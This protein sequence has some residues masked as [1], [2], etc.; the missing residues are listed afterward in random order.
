MD[1]RQLRYFV[2]IVEHGSFSRAAT[3]LNVAQPALSLHVR[4]MEEA[5]GTPLLHRN[6]RGVTVTEAGAILL[7]H[8]RGILDQLALGEEEIRGRLNDPS[9]TV[10]LGL[11]GTISHI[12]AVP[13]ITAARTRWP[14]I[15]LRIAEAMS[16]FVLEWMR[17]GRIDLAVLYDAVEDHGI[18]TERLLEED[19]L[20]FGPA[21]A[22]AEAGLPSQG[23]PVTFATLAR[24]PLI[25]PG[26]GHGLRDLLT[27]TA[28]EEGV[29]LDTVMDV[30]SYNNIKELVAEGLGFSVL[31]EHAI[32][33]E[34]AAGRLQL[35]PVR[36][37]PL[38]RSVYLARPGDR[39][40]TSAA[41]A[42]C[43]LTAATLIDLARSARWIG[44]KA[45]RRDEA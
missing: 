15:R 1:I 3:V 38:R 31:P 9:G 23:R 19:L 37:P 10:K 18:R 2:A 44:A 26:E 11:P 5:L 20:F 29:T 39:P 27:R 13:L 14:K 33:R 8:A 4:N 30:D 45:V 36:D 24:M 21:Q 22:A 17:E 41:Q 42:I 28:R 12:L 34:V 16:G 6:P 35:W 32:A 7:R 43:E 40:V 25:L